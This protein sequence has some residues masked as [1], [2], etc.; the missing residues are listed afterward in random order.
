MAGDE[1]EWLSD[2]MHTQLTPFLHLAV[3]LGD[4]EKF[5]GGYVPDAWV[6]SS[7]T[8][9]RAAAQLSRVIATADAKAYEGR[10]RTELA[11]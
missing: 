2:Q 3:R 5:D 1:L 8:A 6:Q 7:A 9:M 11:A 4:P 10:S